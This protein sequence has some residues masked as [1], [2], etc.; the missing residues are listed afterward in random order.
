MA[1][2]ET[3]HPEVLE[4]EEL[5]WEIKDIAGDFAGRL[6]LSGPDRAALVSANRDL[7][8]IKARLI[9][10]RDKRKRKDA[11]A[12]EQPAVE[13]PVAAKPEQQSLETADGSH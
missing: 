3:E 10:V 4:L 9:D 2:T 13:Q 11:P 6:S 7:Q 12:D 5:A 1:K 8:R